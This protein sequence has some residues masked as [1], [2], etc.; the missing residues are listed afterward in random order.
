V[1]RE[2]REI[3]VRPIRADDLRAVAELIDADRLPGRPACDLRS[4][5]RALSGDFPGDPRG[6][7][8]FGEVRAVVAVDEGQVVGAA[9]YATKVTDGSG[10]L[11]WLHA[12]EERAVAE[13]LLDHVLRELGDSTRCHAFAVAT[14]LSFGVEALPIR[15]RP[16]THAALRARGFERR[17]SW[18]Y[19]IARLDHR[20]TVASDPARATVE[21]TVGWGEYPAWR[22]SMETAQGPAAVLEVGLGPERCGLLQDLQVEP[23]YRDRG[24]ERTLLRQGM[25]LLRSQGAATVV[26]FVET[27]R[28]SAPRSEGML[29]LLSGAGF[30][31]V[32]ELWSYEIPVAGERRSQLVRLP[33]RF[34]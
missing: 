20:V 12:R 6:W 18:R 15:G 24:V 19:L 22:L 4:L 30:E 33:T 25:Q 31:E 21:P 3:E 9:S 17:A 10:W 23:S 27:P 1:A 11:L 16:S 5:R 26:A 13:R 34:W 7:S 28:R 29:E 14:A 2:R 8:G 32:D